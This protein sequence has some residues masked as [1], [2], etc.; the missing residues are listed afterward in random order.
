VTT[1]R[2]VLNP[3]DA[4]RAVDLGLLHPDQVT[5][6]PALPSDSMTAEP[7]VRVMRGSTPGAKGTPADDPRVEAFARKMA[8]TFAREHDRH[9]VGDIR[10]LTSTDD[11]RYPDSVIHH[12]EC[13]TR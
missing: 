4:A 3:T 8:A 9:I 2:V 11:A 12:F 6:P 5:V 1:L 13:D 7:A 10:H